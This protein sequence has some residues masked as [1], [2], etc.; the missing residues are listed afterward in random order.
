MSQ[1]LP[2][3]GP[4]A[5]PRSGG[6]AKQL[7]ILLHG[8]GADGNDL[9]GLA[10]HLGEAL[11]DAA[12]VA[13]NAPFAC[14]MGPYG[15]QW[16]SLQD[17]SSPARL[18]GVNAVAATLNTF[19]DEQ[20]SKHGLRDDRMALVGFSQGTM[21]SLH[22]G[23]RRPRACAAIVGFSGL[24]IAPELLPAE[25]ASKPKVLLVHGDADDIVPFAAMGAAV[26]GLQAVGVP[27]D[28][29][30]R[31]GLTHGIDGVGLQRATEFLKEAFRQA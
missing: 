8:L 14:D 6:A 12:F 20:L 17:R 1:V 15:Y 9:F 27:V 31:P 16:F 7:I 13:P 29:M 30:I 4:E 24:L 25:I 2:L 3:S 28:S 23:L 19:I 5:P 21:V 10:P 11:P 18:A 22:V 26:D